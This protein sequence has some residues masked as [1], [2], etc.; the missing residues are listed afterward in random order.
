ML[1]NQA[2]DN[3]AAQSS[4]AEPAD[5]EEQ[6]QAASINHAEADGPDDGASLGITTSEEFAAA[7]VL[8]EHRLQHRPAKRLKQALESHNAAVT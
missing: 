7:A 1:A 5:S 6:W 3:M 8:A 2:L 4:A